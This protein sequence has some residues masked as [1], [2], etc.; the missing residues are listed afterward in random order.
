M[1]CSANGDLLAAS[2]PGLPAGVEMVPHVVKPPCIVCRFSRWL[3]CGRPLQMLAIRARCLLD[4]LAE[5]PP[6]VPSRH[7]IR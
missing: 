4:Q 5:Y 6:N 3:R 2:D 1:V 7:G